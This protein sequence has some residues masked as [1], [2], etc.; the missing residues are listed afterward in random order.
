MST[1]SE[2]LL[3]TGGAG[4]IGSHTLVEML[5]QGHECV[6]LDN[7]ANSCQESLR[8]V[9]EITGKSITFYKVDILDK[10]ALNEVF[11]KHKFT[12]VVHFAGLKAV[13]E[14]CS[15]PLEYYRVNVTG[16]QTLF[17]CM[18]KHGVKN[19]VFS[20]SATVYGTPRYLPLD[21]QHPIGGCS[22]PY[23][24]T[25]YIIEIMLQDLATSDPSWNIVTLRY[26]NPVGSHKSGKIGEDPQDI[27]NNLM[28]YLSQ[29][30]VG[31]RT[32]LNVFGNDYDTKD[33][34]GIRDYIHVVDLA[35]GHVAALKE[36][37]KECG[38]KTYNLGTGVGYSVLDLLAA[39]ETA[40]GKEIP[41]KI[42]ER[43]LGDVGT[44]YGNPGK[45][46]K[47]LGWKATRGVH[48]MCEDVWRWQSN[49]PMGYRV[50]QNG[51]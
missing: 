35:L 46:L 48:E 37:R 2:C 7:F 3:L 19:L 42:T 26:F 33:G 21:E 22:N 8:R 30:C 14:S 34:T 43:R 1:P 28:P 13:G 49:N 29:V 32:H 41:Y 45:A 5:N 38:Y 17:E 16:A 25:K 6:V 10:E 47:E 15:K 9:E 24:N 39:M 40:S 51:E 27:P 11:T 44:N 20:S 36:I 31:R 50:Q 4:Y 18:G 23:G 12:C